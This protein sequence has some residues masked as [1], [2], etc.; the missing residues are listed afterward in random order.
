MHV[1][2]ENPHFD[3]AVRIGHGQ[4]FGA[5]AN[6]C[7]QA[8]AECLRAVRDSES[9]KLLGLNWEQF[10]SQHAGLSRAAAENLIAKLTEFGEQYFRL[11]QLVRISADTYREIAPRIEGAEIEIGGEK[12]AIVPEN[13]ER[14]RKAVLQLRAKASKQPKPAPPPQ[15]PISAKVLAHR[16]GDLFS[17][18]ERGIETGRE[19]IS[20]GV[21]LREINCQVELILKQF[22]SLRL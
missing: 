3:L 15:D 17:D 12:V 2:N 20:F 8:Q 1:E 21:L 18:I 22:P 14:I 11:S 6:K 13:A 16:F 5:L 7:A 9:Y 4:A 19:N 10:C